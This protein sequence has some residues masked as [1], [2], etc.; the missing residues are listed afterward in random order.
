[1]KVAIWDT[2]VTKED[3]T[4]MHFDIIVPE[5][6]KN[7][8]IIYTFGKQYL[9]SKNLGNRTLSAQEC[10]FCHLETATDTILTDIETQ[11]FH[12]LEMQ[13]CNP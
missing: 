10:R 6:I 3:G 4:L 7:E 13:N 12:I 5:H 1:M 8:E 9:R 2:Y 11:G